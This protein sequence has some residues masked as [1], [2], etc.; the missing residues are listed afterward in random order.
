MQ[1]DSPGALGYVAV[2]FLGIL[3]S[4]IVIAVIAF[5]RGRVERK[6]DLDDETRVRSIR[7][8]TRLE[9]GTDPGNGHDLVQSLTLLAHN[10]GDLARSVTQSM[11][12]QNR[13]MAGFSA[14]IAEMNARLSESIRATDKRIERIEQWKDNDAV[15]HRELAKTIEGAVLAATVKQTGSRSGG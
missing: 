6:H 3:V 11:G 10:L 7:T 5:M 12:E 1:G 9:L 4:A 2:A 13:I 14:Q 8:E 15:G